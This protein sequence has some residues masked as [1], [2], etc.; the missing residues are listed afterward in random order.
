MCDVIEHLLF[1]SKLPGKRA[2]LEL[3][4]QFAQNATAEEINCCLSYKDYDLNNSPEEFVVMCGVLGLCM[5]YKSEPQI[6]LSK[7]EAYANSN[8]WRVREAAAMGIQELLIIK[9]KEVLNILDEWSLKNE[10]YKRC[11]IA[12]LC[13]PKN[14]ENKYILDSAF[15][16]LNMFT[17][18]YNS[19]T[20]KLSEDQKILRKA[21][22][23]AWSVAIVADCNKGK[24][25]FVKLLDS[26]NKNI[27]WIVKN[28]LKKNRLKKIDVEWVESLL[29][30]LN[31]PI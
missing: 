16:Y 14:L 26:D 4:W 7:I 11:I 18:D 27:R 10:R 9:T 5:M 15:K 24:S 21:L 23:Y 30:L 19:Y 28:N 22:G 8:S 31:G 29:V 12:G 13:E 17:N 6:A 1:N 20:S 3:M 2:N 25:L